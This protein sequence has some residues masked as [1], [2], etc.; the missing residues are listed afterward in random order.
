MYV[1]I[2]MTTTVPCHLPS[3]AQRVAVPSPRGATST[4]TKGKCNG[5]QPYLINEIKIDKI[6]LMTA[7]HEE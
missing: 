7:K 2:S 6:K 1:A 4:E 3:M 5:K